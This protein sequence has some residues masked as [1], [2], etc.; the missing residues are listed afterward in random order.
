VD[1]LNKRRKQNG[2]LT[3]AVKDSYKDLNAIEEETHQK[4]KRIKSALVNKQHK[5]KCMIAQR[6]APELLSMQQPAF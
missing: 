6:A 4:M 3:I 1:L 2:D 5:S